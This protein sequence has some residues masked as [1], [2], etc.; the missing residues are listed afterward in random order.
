[1]KQRE[2]DEAEGGGL[3]MKERKRM[4]ERAEDE[5]KGGG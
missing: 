4:K 2:E 1:M 5:A 3:R